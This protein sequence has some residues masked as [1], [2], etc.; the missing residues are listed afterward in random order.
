MDK[1]TEISSSTK[2]KLKLNSDITEKFKPET[3]EDTLHQPLNQFDH[4]LTTQLV[5]FD[6]LTFEKNKRRIWP[7]QRSKIETT[8]LSVSYTHLT[9]PTTP[10]V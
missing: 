7:M 1:Q 5:L 9:L 4:H 10:Y 2:S 8:A 6:Q 3:C